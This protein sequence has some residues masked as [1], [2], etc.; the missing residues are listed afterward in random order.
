MSRSDHMMPIAFDCITSDNQK[1][2]LFRWDIRNYI[3]S[4]YLC[5]YIEVCKAKKLWQVDCF[6]SKRGQMSKNFT[7][8][9]RGVPPPLSSELHIIRENSILEIQA[10]F[11][12]KKIQ[13]KYV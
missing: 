8:S 7:D 4:I 13:Y 1:T 12:K 10:V 3:Q 6:I 2:Y 11:P 5:T 9:S